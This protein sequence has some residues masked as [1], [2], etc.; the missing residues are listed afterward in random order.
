MFQGLILQLAKGFISRQLEKYLSGI[1]WA[2][3]KADC[4][5][6]IRALVPGVWFDDEAAAV[7]A[8]A[9]DIAE[10]AC[11][12]GAAAQKLLDAAAKA[13]SGDAAGAK[14]DLKDLAEHIWAEIVLA[15]K[16]A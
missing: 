12:E 4:D 6:R 8:K 10:A 5:A 11:K 15:L 3:V 14:A 7:V 16:G 13:A 1:D 9:I 2:K